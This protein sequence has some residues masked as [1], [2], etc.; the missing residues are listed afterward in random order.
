MS[1][2]DKRFRL[3]TS[4]S[5]AIHIAYNGKVDVHCPHC[6]QG[7]T[8]PILPLTPIVVCTCI[9]CGGYVVPFAGEL[10]PIP[11]LVVEQGQD[12]DIRFAI[13]QVIMK[14]LHGCVQEMLKQKFQLTEGKT[15][16]DIDIDVPQSME[17][18]EKLWG[19]DSEQ[20]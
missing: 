2:E 17:D 19:E 10:L 1:P 13:I 7:M 8:V 6:N 4:L 15:F 16:G 5:S 9:E 18:L 3:L 20:V 12:V 11:K 14:L